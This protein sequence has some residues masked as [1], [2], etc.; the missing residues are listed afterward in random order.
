MRLA[1]RSGLFQLASAVLVLAASQ[2]A[3]AVPFSA[4]LTLQLGTAPASVGSGS[5]DG[6]SAGAGGTATIPGGILPVQLTQVF[7]PPFFDIISGFAVGAP[8]KLNT[9]APIPVGSNLALSWN[10]STGTMGL[11]AS[12]YLLVKSGKAAAAIP[13]QIIGVGGTFTGS[14]FGGLLT[15]EVVA[16]PF[17]LGMATAIGTAGGAP[18][19]IHA[20]TGFDARTAAGLGRSSW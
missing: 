17:Q 12:A 4:T 1:G 3:G 2:P 8:G 11:F 7:A 6:L 10:G 9:K 18:A 13:F 16:N 19:T 20:G 15:T 14:N 5:G